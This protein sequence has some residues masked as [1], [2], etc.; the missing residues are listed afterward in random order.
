MINRTAVAVFIA[1]MFI[2]PT[3][4]AQEVAANTRISLAPLFD[5][6]FNTI[7]AV[8]ALVIPLLIRHYLKKLTGIKIEKDAAMA[9]DFA[10]HK[11]VS[12]GI[13]QLRILG[14]KIEDV[15][16]HNELVK[17]AADYALSRVP[18]AVARFNASPEALAQ[19]ALARLEERLNPTP[20]PI[21]INP[22]ATNPA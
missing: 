8:L 12:L 11:G 14:K 4:F 17:S 6:I 3:A 13:G 9:L 5:Y 16:V 7:A 1:I 22:P 15:N 19:M 20:P 10:I 2:V 18:D 21:P